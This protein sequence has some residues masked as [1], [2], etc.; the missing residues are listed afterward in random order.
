MFWWCRKSFII[1]WCVIINARYRWEFCETTVVNNHTRKTRLYHALAGCQ[2]ESLG[3]RH[4]SLL[5]INKI[6][7]FFTSVPCA[8]LSLSTAHLISGE[9][10]YKHLPS[11]QLNPTR[12][13]S[14][15][16]TQR[17]TVDSPTIAAW[18]PFRLFFFSP[19]RTRL[20]SRGIIFILVYENY[21]P[22]AHKTVLSESVWLEMSATWAS[23][24]R[25][26]KLH[27][28]P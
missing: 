6:N 19:S 23:R 20:S 18:I 10:L 14:H 4:S 25:S 16:A 3:V 11:I 5:T 9:C 15:L 12:E 17:A 1:S 8:T 7:F 22:P 2:Q 28:F 13:F 24:S 21:F 26:H 27:F